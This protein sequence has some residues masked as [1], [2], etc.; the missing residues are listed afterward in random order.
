M[1]ERTPLRTAAV[2]AACGR[3]AAV[4]P[5]THLTSSLRAHQRLVFDAVRLVGFGAEATA[6]VGFVIGVVALEPHRLAVAL[7]GE[8]VGGD[9][10]QEPAVVGDDD[11]AAGIVE[12]RLFKRAQRVDVKIVVGSSRRSRLAPSFSIFAR[13]TRLRSPPDNC[14]TFFCWSEPRKLKSAQ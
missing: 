11:G 1:P 5:S 2:P 10:V 4:R 13:W 9:A 3:D 7:E 6:A 8:D 14:P 12:E